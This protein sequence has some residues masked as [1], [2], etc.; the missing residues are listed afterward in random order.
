ME[1]NAMCSEKRQMQ[2]VESNVEMNAIDFVYAC[3]RGFCHQRQI[4]RNEQKNENEEEYKKEP[5]N[6]IR[7]NLISKTF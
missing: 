1:K 7:F 6:N 3:K 2:K 4:K 5:L